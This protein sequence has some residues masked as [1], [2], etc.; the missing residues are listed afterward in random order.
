MLRILRLFGDRG[1]DRRPAGLGCSN[2]RTNLSLSTA[3]AGSRQIPGLNIFDSS[4]PT[5]ADQ[6]V[7]IV[8]CVIHRRKGLHEREVDGGLFALCEETGAV[9]GFDGPAVQAWQVLQE[10][11]TFAALNETL[12]GIYDVDQA[13]CADQ[14]RRVIGKFDEWG[15]VTLIKPRRT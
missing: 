8:D 4:V 9:Y 12:C 10:P 14:M 15:L 6:R 2:E 1:Q 11:L 13:T 7:D 3:V 5:K